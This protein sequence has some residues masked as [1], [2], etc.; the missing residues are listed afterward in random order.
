MNISLNP[1][2][3]CNFKC[4]HCYLSQKQLRD[5]QLLPLA[6]AKS[7]LKKI[8][9]ELGKIECIDLYG[10]EIAVLP[11]TYLNRL[12]DVCLRFADRVNIITNYSFIH[13]CFQRD[14]I[15]LYVSYDF[16]AREKH[17]YVFQ[18]IL[19]STCPVHI[20]TL[21]TDFL[22]SRPV[23][24]MART[25][26]QVKNLASFEIKPYS[27]NQ[28]NQQPFNNKDYEMFIRSFIEQ[29]EGSGI[30]FVN[31]NNLDD[32]LNGTR[33][34]YSDDHLYITPK[35]TF[36]VLEFDEFNN[37]YF[38]EVTVDEYKRWCSRERFT[39]D[40]TEPCASCE[41][42]GRCL[43]EHLKPIDNFK[44]NS[45]SGFYNLIKW[46]EYEYKS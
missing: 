27:S 10:G 26:K 33:Q 1:T 37:E 40:T 29:L 39:Y 17:E 32:V 38:K 9:C 2:Y 11:E 35:G 43:T 30:D 42:K 28:A 16:E 22:M 44:E 23:D 41:Y 45:C 46:Y 25:L 7:L 3:Y 6:V 12:I 8:E 34:S 14:D 5:P 36:A 31:V 19:K 24:V 15:N 20:I 13:P 4:P 18:N 21:A